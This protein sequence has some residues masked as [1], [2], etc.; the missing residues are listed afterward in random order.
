MR[1]REITHE[2]WQHFLGDFA[3]LH[4][5]EH[6]NVETIG[7]GAFGVRSQMCD[8]PLIGIVDTEPKARPDEEWIEIIAGDSPATAAIHAIS[9][10]SRVVIAEEEDGQDVALQIDSADGL[11]TMVRFEPPLEGMPAG[12]T[13]V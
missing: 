10:P 9:H 6:V 13:V 4:Q 5:G 3:Q 8:Q 2:R 12:F 7:E 1:T 11:I